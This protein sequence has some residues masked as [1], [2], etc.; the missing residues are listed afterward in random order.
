MKPPPGTV[1][2]ECRRGCTNC[3]E[4]DGYVYF[5]EADIQNAASFLGTTIAEFEKRYIY[6]TKHMRRMR[7]PRGKRQCHFLFEG[8]CSIHP[9]KPLQC[10]LFP[11]WPELLESR[12]AWRATARYCPG[13]GQGEL[14]QI[15]TALEAAAEM[16][17]AAGSQYQVG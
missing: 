15:G 8:G 2:F 16:K 6:R 14:I 1:R 5:T 3:C 11:F 13:I 4:V 9:A 12:S 10:K 17:S 7:K